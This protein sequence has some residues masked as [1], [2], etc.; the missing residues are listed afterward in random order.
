MSSRKIDRPGL[1]AA[2]V[3]FAPPVIAMPMR[4]S[5]GIICFQKRGERGAAAGPSERGQRSLA[6]ALIRPAATAK[7]N[8]TMPTNLMLVT[9]FGGAAL[10]RRSCHMRL[11]RRPA[12]AFSQSSTNSVPPIPVPAQLETNVEVRIGADISAGRVVDIPGLRRD[13]S[14]AAASPPDAVTNTRGSANVVLV[15]MVMSFA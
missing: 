13:V 7:R 8:I 15:N 4:T 14:L 10:S 12:S 3:G 6:L 1:R 9:T 5:A 2:P 11:A